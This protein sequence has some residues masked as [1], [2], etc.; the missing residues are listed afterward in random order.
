[1]GLTRQTGVS[2]YAMASRTPKPVNLPNLVKRQERQS[3]TARHYVA[4]RMGGKSW[5]HGV[6]EEN[7]VQMT[8]NIMVAYF[9]N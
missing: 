3:L 1:M 2:G 7:D 5:D 4:S 9:L 6:G 8:S